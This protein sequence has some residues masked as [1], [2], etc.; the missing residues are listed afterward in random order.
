MGSDDVLDVDGVVLVRLLV[1]PKKFTMR[2][3]TGDLQSLLWQHDKATARKAAEAAIGRLRETGYVWPDTKF[4]LTDDGEAAALR[5]LGLSSLPQRQKA[6]WRWARKR[7]LVQRLRLTTGATGDA[8]RSDHLAAWILAFKEKLQLGGAPTPGAVL[9]A[10]AW[11]SLG[12]PDRGPLRGTAA[13][14]ALLELTRPDTGRSASTPAAQRPAP[15]VAKIESPSNKGEPAGSDTASADLQEFARSVDHV[16]LSAKTGTWAGNKVYIAQVWRDF[17]PACGAEKPSLDAFKARLVAA[18]R[19]GQILLSR[20]DLVGAYPA[21]ALRES[22][23]DVGGE[24]YH[25]VETQHLR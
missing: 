6:D 7:L 19:A 4:V 2:E 25:F 12:L 17:K 15:I 20:A 23:I 24:V 11:R 8:G 5:R 14:G 3:L 21:D 10:L 18:A 13:I 22:Q 9:R 1:R 16:A